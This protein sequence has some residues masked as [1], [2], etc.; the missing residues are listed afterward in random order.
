V[1]TQGSRKNGFTFLCEPLHPKQQQPREHQ[2]VTVSKELKGYIKTESMILIVVVALAAGFLGGVA[3][4]A[5]RASGQMAGVP[6][7]N[8]GP[9]ALTADQQ[10]Q[11]A[12]L[13]NKTKTDPGD[14]ISWTRLGHLYF[15]TDQPSLAIDAYK[16]SLQLDPERPDL[17]TDIGV[18]YR[19]NG[20]PQQAVA[21][22]DRA[23]S[24]DA[25]HEISLFNKGVVMMHDL[26]N[27][28]G[29][30]QSWEKLIQ[31]NPRAEAPGGQRVSDL[32]D[33]LKKSQSMNQ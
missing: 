11:L 23:L 12:D 10:Q 9:S 30:L 1:P 14:A 8:K 13:I 29:A 26:S 18:M 19:R 28:D 22:F 7:T 33:Q 25:R 20:N 6:V 5:F 17:W 3:F 32:V 21:S 16:K 4:S 27:P 15:D 2:V 24:I 31:I